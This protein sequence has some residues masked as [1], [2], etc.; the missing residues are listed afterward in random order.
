IPETQ[1]RQD[2]PGGI[3]QINAALTQYPGVVADLDTRTTTGTRSE[4]SNAIGGAMRNPNGPGE[5]GDNPN[6][7]FV[8]KLG[9]W[10]NRSGNLDATT[11][12]LRTTPSVTQ[13][14][15]DDYL[16]GQKYFK[17]SKETVDDWT[18]RLDRAVPVGLKA[19][20]EASAPPEP[21][22]LFNTKSFEADVAGRNLLNSDV[23][24]RNLLNTAE[25]GLRKAGY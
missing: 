19:Y 10:A 22:N 9:G 12:F 14:A 5:L 21:G 25:V 24:S 17:D 2:V 6:P 15:F 20:D 3:E 23:L 1:F 4:V 11:E 13:A 8:A 18:R 16:R 7:R